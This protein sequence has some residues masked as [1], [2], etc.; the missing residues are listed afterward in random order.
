MQAIYDFWNAKEVV[1]IE[2]LTDIDFIHFILVG[3]KELEK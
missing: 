1:S 3:K 2:P